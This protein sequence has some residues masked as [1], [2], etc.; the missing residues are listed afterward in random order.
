MGQKLSEQEREGG[1]GGGANGDTA[2]AAA[3]IRRL[4]SEKHGNMGTVEVRRF[5]AEEARTWLRERGFDVKVEERDLGPLLR[6]AG[7]PHAPSISHTQWADLIAITNSDF[8]LNNYG[9]GM[10]VD[11]AV[12][13]ARQRYETE[14]GAE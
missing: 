11:E 8:V 2:S 7:H 5:S 13:R 10:T 14:Q 3:G 1:S 6:E 4:R 9:S 12:I